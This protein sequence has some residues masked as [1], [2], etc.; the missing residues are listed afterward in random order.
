MEEIR[1]TF[2]RDEG[3]FSQAAIHLGGVEILF[4]D[5][6]LALAAFPRLLVAYVLWKAEQE[7]PTRVTVF[8]MPQSRTAFLAM[9]FGV[10]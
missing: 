8:L 6:T 3:E 10:S 9:G 4:G 1:L 7:L 2:N 5:Q